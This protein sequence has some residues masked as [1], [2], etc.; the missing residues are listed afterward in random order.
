M[1]RSKLT[2]LVIMALAVSFLSACGGD[3]GSATNT[4]TG[5][6]PGY[7]DGILVQNSPTISTM[8]SVA[9][10]SDKLTPSLIPSAGAPLFRSPAASSGNTINGT[11]ANQ[12]FSVN[13]SVTFYNAAGSQINSI[14]NIRDVAKYVIVYSGTYT[15][16]VT[17]NGTTEVSNLTIESFSLGDAA[18]FSGN[19][20]GTAVFKIGNHTINETSVAQFTVSIN[21]KTS[22]PT[23]TYS[24]QSGT[25][26]LNGSDGWGLYLTYG[27]NGFTGTV[28]YNGV[29]QG[30]IISSS[31]S[32]V[33][34]DGE[35]NKSITINY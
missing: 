29:D 17:F 2:L 12:P 34:T 33:I 1:R 31:N 11:L 24:S 26:T 27:P 13:Y 20:N 32:L 3:G 4:A 15:Q 35:N 23:Y 10:L 19:S 16:E 6:G 18:K 8:A 9:P 5:T 25:K 30:S 21:Y 28:K 7:T 14:A 22:P